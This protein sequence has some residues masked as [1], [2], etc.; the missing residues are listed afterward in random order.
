MSQTMD[1]ITKLHQSFVYR[2]I[3]ETDWESGTDGPLVVE[4]DTTESCDLA[5]PGCISQDIMETQNRFSDERLLELGREMYE[6]GVKAVVLIGGGEPLAHPAVGDLMEYFGTHDMRIGITTNGTFIRKYLDIIAEYSSWTRVSMD[7]GS[8]ELFNKLRPAKSG[9]GS[10][11]DFIVE[12]MEMLAKVKKGKLGYSYLIQTAADGPGVISNVNEIYQAAELARDIGCDYF[13]VKPSYQFREGADHA[14]VRHDS[15]LMGA[16]K[17][18]V[19]RLE[20][21]ETDSFK[22]IRAINLKYSLEDCEPVQLKSYKKCPATE[23][24]TLVCPSGAFVCP[25]WRGKEDMRI[26]ELHN[27]SFADM[28]NGARRKEVMNHLDASRHCH[29]YCLRHQSNEE[30]IKIIEKQKSNEPVQLVEEFDRFI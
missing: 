11:F 2:K 17:E 21:L 6:A 24:R 4:L 22:I 23:L 3:E 28:W 30:V 29:F 5:C 10:R 19:E 8:S 14:L 9:K 16:A 13:E 27:T 20:E 26:G 18:E 7:A 15:E 25:Y 1:L 12:N